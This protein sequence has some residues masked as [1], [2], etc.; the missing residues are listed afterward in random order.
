MTQ[1]STATLIALP[2][3]ASLL[4]VMSY[5]KTPYVVFSPGITVDVLGDFDGKS[6]VQVSGH[7]TYQDD[8]QMRMTT[9]FRTPPA[10]RVSLL[11][12][13]K[14]WL[15]KDQA[16]YQRDL[17]YPEGQTNEESRQESAVEMVSSQDAA[18]ANAMRE[19]GYDVKEV[20]EVLAV[21]PDLPADGKLEVRDVFVKVG[22]DRV[23]SPSQLVDLVQAAPA[24]EPLTF[25]VRRAGERKRVTI[26]PKVVDGANRIGVVPGPGYVFPFD[27]SF[28]IDQSIG[29][30]SAGLM[31]SL[32]LYDVLTPGSLT[33][34]ATIAGTG[35]IDDA[36]RV[37]PIGGLRQKIVAARE[38]G[39]GLF[40]VPADNC[41]QLVGAQPGDM[42]LARATT[43]HQALR[44]VERWSADHDT[45]LPTCPAGDDA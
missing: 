19:L 34:G 44:T 35:T 42:R 26:T 10:G 21:S 39:A 3:L 11:Y 13:V 37:G 5:V 22:G 33:D 14:T 2:V 23:T 31:F 45:T 9:V 40:L 36:G 8:G 12:A 41:D 18:I 28:N 43:M 17:I 6:V 27:V 24:G 7:K 29:G 16:I 1:R 15:D 32:G 30:P 20:T 38:A 4:F 25:T